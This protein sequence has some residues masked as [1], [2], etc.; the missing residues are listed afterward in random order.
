M[1][2]GV[3]C[4]GKEWEEISLYYRMVDIKGRRFGRLTSLFPVMCRGTRQWLCQCDCGNYIVVAY[5]VLNS[6]NTK[7]CGCG[8]SIAAK[9]RWSKYREE[10]NVI[11]QRFGRLVVDSFIGIADEGA[12]YRFRC[13]CGNVIDLPINRVKTGNTNSCGCLWTEWKDY[14][15][16]DIIGQK[17]G[18]LTVLSYVGIDNH[19]S[20][21]FECLCDCGNTTV[22]TRYSLTD[23]RTQSCGCL[24]SIGE[25][26]I[27]NILNTHNISYKSQF[28]FSD[29]VSDMGRCLPYDF[30]IFDENQQIKRLIEFDGDQHQKP[31]EYFGGEEKFLRVQ[32]N[33]ALKNQYALSHNI[34]FVRIPY[35]KRDSMVLEDL[36]GPQYLIKEEK[37]YGNNYYENS[38]QERFVRKLG[39]SS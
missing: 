18:K 4:K 24:T 8:K 20:T 15:K 27:K 22:V 13:D 34:P 30:A 11:G 36:L 19:G 26:N 32:K 31:Y 10:V 16:T 33:D 37:I 21:T 3:D 17:F 28:I 5:N 39:S 12:I 38:I 7:S 25:N 35:S 1:R 6:K 2:R 9:Q 29:L 14:T 23:N